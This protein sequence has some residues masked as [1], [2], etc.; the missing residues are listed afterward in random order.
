MKCR[1][2]SMKS[3][4]T[5]VTVDDIRKIVNSLKMEILEK[6]ELIY[7]SDINGFLQEISEFKKIDMTNIQPTIHYT[8]ILRRGD[9]RGSE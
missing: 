2:D 1:R 8:D 4:I 3:R 9:S 6:D 7:V 5:S